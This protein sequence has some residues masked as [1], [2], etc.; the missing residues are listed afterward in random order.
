M[1][2]VIFSFI[3]LNIKQIVSKKA[4]SF[5]EERK[6]IKKGKRKRGHKSAE[7]LLY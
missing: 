3:N 2:H 5:D 1:F 7:A 6:R 4:L